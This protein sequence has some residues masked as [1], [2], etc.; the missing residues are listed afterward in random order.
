[1]AKAKPDETFMA[2]LL[3]A[4]LYKRNQGRLTRQLT[5]AALA[6]ILYLGMWSFSNN[7]LADLETPVIPVP[8][9]GTGMPARVWLPVALAIVGTWVV[10]RAVNYPRFADFLISVEAEVDKVTWASRAELHRATI[11]VL[12]VMFSL[13]AVLFLLDWLWMVVFRGVGIVQF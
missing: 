5:G 10:Y 1:M 4:S 2:G 13:G 7:L 11:V 3:S 8:G 12:A 6:L 9:L